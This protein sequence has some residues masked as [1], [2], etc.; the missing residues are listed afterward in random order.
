MLPPG[1]ANTGCTA[2]GVPGNGTVEGDVVLHQ[3]MQVGLQLV[4]V[5]LHACQLTPQLLDHGICA[6]KLGLEI[7]LLCGVACLLSVFFFFFMFVGQ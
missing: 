3:V 1:Q 2:A 7:G 5:C 6:C 4:A